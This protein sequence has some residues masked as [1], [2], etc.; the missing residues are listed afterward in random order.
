M[1]KFQQ[2][3]FM[4]ATCYK[5]DKK[6]NKHLNNGFYIDFTIFF[7]LFQCENMLIFSNVC[8]SLIPERNARRTPD[9]QQRH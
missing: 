6:S 2:Q 5:A 9:G 4:K 1:R 7:T 8:L 3:V